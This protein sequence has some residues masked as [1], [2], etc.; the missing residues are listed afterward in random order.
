MINRKSVILI[1]SWIQEIMRAKQKPL[2][3][4]LDFCKMK[5]IFPLHDL[6]TFYAAQTCWIEVIGSEFA[7]HLDR[8]WYDSI[9]DSADPVVK[10]MFNQISMIGSDASFKQ[11]IY[12]RL[13]TEDSREDHHDSGFATFDFEPQ[14][15]MGVVVNPGF[16]VGQHKQSYQ[17]AVIR[18]ILKTWYVYEERHIVRR[19]PL[20]LQYLQLLRT[21]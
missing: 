21:K 17:H 12:E 19:E 11:N 1:P 4:C 16:F 14:R 7:N 9:R 15:Y 20:Y 13:F 5:E 6:A 3:E 18:A 8:A 10:E 2:S